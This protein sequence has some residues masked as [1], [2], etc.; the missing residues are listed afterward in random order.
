MA[1]PNRPHLLLITTDQQRYDALGINGNRLIETP[2]LDAMAAGGVNFSRG[3]VTCPVCIPARRTLISGQSP[4][5]HG[6]REYRDGLEWNPP[7]TLPG[8]LSRA[9]YQTQLIGK[10]HLHPQGKRY[11]FDHIILSESMNSRPTSPEQSRNDYVRWLR[12]QGVADHPCFHGISG[13]GRLALPWPLEDRLHHNNW[14]AQE[15]VQFLTE[16]RDP[17]SPFFLHLSFTHPHPPLV[18]PRDYFERYL[19]KDLGT[20]TI[21][22]WAPEAVPPHLPLSPDSATGPFDP[23]IIRRARAAYFALINHIDDCVAFVLE[24][25]MEYGN[26]RAREPLYVLFSSDHG[27]MLGDHQLFRKSLGY[28]SSAHVPFFVRGYNAPTA[29]G[30]CPDLVCWED[31]APTL[32]DLGGVP[33][34]DS[35]EGRSLAP[36]L[37]GQTPPEPARDFLFGQCGGGFHNLWIV[38]GPWK[39]IWFPATNEEQ[40]FQLEEDPQETQD[41]SGTREALEPLRTRM[42]AAIA[43]RQDLSYVPEK[44]NPCAGA[45]P[46]IFWASDSR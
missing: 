29:K 25:W 33:I 22:D 37:L 18:P 3:Y 12:E 34:P 45:I 43:H 44:L 28:E 38:E 1:A 30:T 23:A 24:R 36:N 42:A 40:L 39:Y 6:L 32:L 10:L 21:G 14:L 31:I 13:N 35:M 16:D 26:P 20:A 27:E 9:G 17:S 11:G 46:Q 8:E 5:T 15:A 7:A 41:R 4:E 2:N 19:E